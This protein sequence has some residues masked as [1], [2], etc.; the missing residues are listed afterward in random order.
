MCLSFCFTNE[1]LLLW[2]LHNPFLTSP[3]PNTIVLHPLHLIQT[4]TLVL[5]WSPKAEVRILKDNSALYKQILQPDW[6]NNISWMQG[7]QPPA[8]CPTAFYARLIAFNSWINFLYQF[9]SNLVFLDFKRLRCH[10][11]LCVP[12]RLV[13]VGA[14]C[15][16]SAKSCSLKSATIWLLCATPEVFACWWACSSLG[17]CSKFLAREDAKD[18]LSCWG[19]LSTSMLSASVNSTSSSSSLSY[20]SS[21]PSVGSW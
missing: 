21:S 10:E 15:Q 13:L 17:N 3:W 8:N 4:R 19:I 20:S 18:A 6:Y 1:M 9:A 16:P 5:L 12:R 11:V 2:S 7:V 14:A